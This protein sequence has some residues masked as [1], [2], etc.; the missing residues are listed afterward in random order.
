MGVLQ[1]TSR[2][3]PRS[4]ERPRH[5]G[6]LGVV[7]AHTGQL[8]AGAAV[9]LVVLLALSIDAPHAQAQGILTGISIPNPI[10]TLLGGIDGGMVDL[11][12]KAFE[13]I[14]KALFTPLAKFVTVDLIGWLT[15]IPNFAQGNVAQ[16]EQTV[17]AICGG[18]LGAVATLSVI[19]YWVAGF[20]GG[21]D[22]GFS[23]L[24]GLVR[25]VGATLFIAI[26]PWVFERAIGLANLLTGALLGSGTTVHDVSTLLRVGL[27][28]GMGVAAV[29]NQV[30]LFLGIVIA[31]ISSLLFLGLLLMKIIVSVS[32]ITLFVGMPFAAV[33]WPVIPWVGR[34]L[35]RAF[36]VCLAVPV[37]WALCFAAAAAL[38]LDTLT[39]NQ[40]TFSANGVLNAL[41]SPLVAIVLLYVMLRLPVHMSRIAMLGGM[42]LGG[43]FVGRAVSYAAGGQLRETARQHLPASIGGRGEQSQSESP[44]ATRLRNAATLAGAAA[45]TGGAGAAAARAAKGASASGLRAASRTGAAS[46]AGAPAGTKTA[47]AAA[48]GRSY[49]PPATAVA[50]AN[51]KALQHGLQ[52]PA[53][54]A[55]D[56]NA[57]KFEAEHRAATSPVTVDEARAALQSLPADT[58]QGIKQLASNHGAGAREHLAYQ[59]TGE[60][61]AE[62]R[63]ALRQLAAASPEIR[64][65]AV[66]DA[67]YAQDGEYASGGSVGTGSVSGGSADE[68]SIRGGVFG[69]SHG[70]E[71]APTANPTVTSSGSGDGTTGGGGGSVGAGSTSGGSVDEGSV[72]GGSFGESHGSEFAPTGDPMVTE[73]GRGS[74]GLGDS[75]SGAS[76]RP[77]GAPD[78]PE[79][80]SG[81]PGTTRDV[82]ESGR[83][84]PRPAGA[85][86]ASAPASP[87][88]DVRAPR[89]PRD[90]NPGDMFRN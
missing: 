36:A 16:L 54:R 25:T 40:L 78:M 68:G 23:A 46:R 8:T 88:T 24:D 17:A 74:G 9:L 52:T 86:D 81:G 82:P 31:V 47:S 13:G 20:A 63:E 50:K 61:T 14:I 18:V 65:Q 90:Q 2:H 59:A 34:L 77:S 83:P 15:T 73:P 79:P 3:R 11:A 66:K 76:E 85:P 10:T 89:Q 48:N 39:F 53:F 58:Q 71:F 64:A 80:A 33:L 67:P 27:A 62:Q 28:G 19:R 57:E 30:G 84:A 41:L 75:G 4:D 56:F 12:V 7:Q 1:R 29:S 49:T 6:L 42:S 26:W 21:G 87:G 22:S 32:T 37:L 5:A 45:A 72:G 51:G 70:S 35:G 43:G 55:E 69:D 44:T 60:W 38:T